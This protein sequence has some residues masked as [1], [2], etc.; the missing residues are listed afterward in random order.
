MADIIEGFIDGGAESWEEKNWTSY[1]T[2]YQKRYPGSM[3]ADRQAV[4]DSGVRVEVLTSRNGLLTMRGTVRNGQRVFFHSS[5]DPVKEAQR[6]V[7]ALEVQFGMVV[8]VYGL[9]L[10]YL[11]EALLEKLDDGTSLFVVEPDQNVFQQAMRAR[12]L[13]GLFTSDR[14]YI[15]VGDSRFNLEDHLSALYSATRFQNAVLTGLNGHQTVYNDFY[16]EYLEGIK[17]VMNRVVM[18]FR[19]WTT[20]GDRIVSSTILNFVDYCTH[21]GVQS[22]FNKMVGMPAIIVGAGPS[23]DRNIALLREAKGR[24]VIIAVGTAVK[25]LQKQGVV[26][27]FVVSI[28]AGAYNYEHFKEFNGQD[29]ALLTDVQTYPQILQTFQGPIFVAAFHSFILNWSDGAVEE[30]G[31]LETGG[32]VANSAMTAAYKMGADP[33]IFVGQ[34]L[35]FARDGHTHAAGT[36]YEQVLS[37]AGE[38]GERFYVKANDGGEVL[39]NRKFDYYRLFFERWIGLNTDRRYINATEGG[40]LIAGMQIMALHEVLNVYC[41]EEVDVRSVIQEQQEGCKLSEEEAIA[42][43]YRR[44]ADADRILDI[45]TSVVKGVKQ[46][47]QACEKRN[48]GKMQKVARNI[49]RIFKGFEEDPYIRPAVEI[50]AHYTIQQINYR[51]NRALYAEDSDVQKAVAD[52]DI[53]YKKIYEEVK[54]VKGLIEEAIK[55]AE[56]RYN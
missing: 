30:K 54:R 16:S 26:P 47:Q 31:G 34:D 44:L 6:V 45:A 14:V 24:A 2:S 42:I 8:V 43:L 48:S 9:G 21:P 1:L 32:T 17:Q 56:E 4:V 18:E 11:A 46:L 33:I 10:G 35:A 5:V 52:Y 28:D 15:Q 53:Y 22:L 50:L 3:L 55:C 51:R 38:D 40:A 49:N 23:L 37:G 25:A 12:D 20:I 39:T 29:T 41:Q 27:D 36:N 19:T 7:S 13:R